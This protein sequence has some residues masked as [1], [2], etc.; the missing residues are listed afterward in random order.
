MIRLNAKNNASTTLAIDINSSQTSITVADGTLF[1]GPPFRATLFDGINEEIVEVS[2]VNGNTWTVIRAQ[3]GTTA[4]A[5]DVGT[6][7][8][9]RWTA[10]MYNEIK[11]A[12]NNP[13]LYKYSFIIPTLFGSLS[14]TYK[15]YG[16]VLAPN[17][18]IYCVP[19]YATR[20][21]EINPE[22]KELT[23]FG[24]L[25]N[26]PNKWAGGVLAPNGKIYCVPHSTSQVLEINPETKELTLF[27]SLSGTDK[28]YGGV[29]APNGKIYC[30]PFN[31]TQVLE[32]NIL[33]LCD[34]YLNKF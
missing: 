30:V 27:G 14:G 33:N 34:R 22:T 18:K 21:L 10:G 2:M 20:V 5:W 29:L 25:S 13:R 8:E 3:E 31:A 23:L 16:G 9:L 32:I 24:S 15:W 12:V 1:P 7:V 4:Q 26:I 11:N 6:L 17:G 28:W 19:H